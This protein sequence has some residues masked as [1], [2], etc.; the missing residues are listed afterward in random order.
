MN[1]QDLHPFDLNHLPT[2]AVEPADPERLVPN[3]AVKAKKRELEKVKAQLAKTVQDYGQDAHDNQEQKRRTM[4]GFKISHAKQGREIKK[5]QDLSREAGTGDQEAAW[6]LQSTGG[7]TQ[8][9]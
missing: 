9:P 2:T 7:R 1:S 6:H 5:L 3:P 4:R 8:D